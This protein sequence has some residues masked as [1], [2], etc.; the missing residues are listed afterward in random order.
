MANTY[1]PEDY[2][3]PLHGKMLW[4]VAR[5][6]VRFT[7][8]AGAPTVDIRDVAKAGLL[9]GLHGKVGERYIIANEF[10]SNWDFY[11]AAAAK[12]GNKPVHVIP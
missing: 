6:K 8:D 12:C 10:I 2:Q 11:S 1:G 4:D 9:A 3:P 7:I 5:G